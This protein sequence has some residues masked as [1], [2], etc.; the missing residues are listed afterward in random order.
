MYEETGLVLPDQDREGYILTGW[1][2]DGAV[3]AAGN[4]FVMPAQN[5]TF[6]AQWEPARGISGT[7]VTDEDGQLMPGVIV[8]LKL[9][10]EVLSLI[11]ISS[12]LRAAQRAL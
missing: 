4:T 12:L 9:G 8:S 11:H 6:E 7:V 5:V 3:Y 2:Y 10:A 1:K